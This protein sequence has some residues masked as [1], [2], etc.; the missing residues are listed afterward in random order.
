MGVDGSFG[1]DGY[2]G[3]MQ[4]VGVSVYDLC[5]CLQFLLACN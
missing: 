3:L 1:L 4:E 2:L 5:L